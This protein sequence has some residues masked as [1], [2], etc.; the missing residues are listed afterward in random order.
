MEQCA[1][2][3]FLTLKK[4]PARDIKVELEGVRGYEA[5]SFGGEEVRQVV[6]QWENHPGRWPTVEKTALKRSL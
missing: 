4:L 5:L 2:V 6:R 3:R 1:I